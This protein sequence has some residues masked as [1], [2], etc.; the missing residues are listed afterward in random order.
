V[1]FILRFRR[2]S[3]KATNASKIIIDEREA[4]NNAKEIKET[5]VKAKKTKASTKANA[6]A[7]ARATTIVA[8]IATTIIDKKRLSKLREQFV[9][10]YIN[11]VLEI[12]S[13][14]LSCLLLFNNLRKYVSNI[15][16]N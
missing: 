16:Y 8:T 6:K 13:I 11:L 5:R 9:C 2:K 12:T 7:N 15:L 1:R 4:K 14:I 3:R 10:I